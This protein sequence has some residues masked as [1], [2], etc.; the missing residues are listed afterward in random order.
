MT[1][2]LALYTNLQKIIYK[3]SQ[4]VAQKNQIITQYEGKIIQLAAE[5]EAVRAW[6]A[7]QEEKNVTQTPQAFFN[8]STGVN[9]R[10]TCTERR[11]NQPGN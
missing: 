8:P 9:P 11:T 1:P 7:Q 6:R 2:A 4:N 3:N 5:A 10:P